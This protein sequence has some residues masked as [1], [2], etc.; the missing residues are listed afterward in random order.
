MVTGVSPPPSACGR[1]SL[2]RASLSDLDAL[3]RLRDDPAVRKYLG[4]PVPADASLEKANGVVGSDNHWVVEVSPGEVAG[5]VSL[6]PRGDDVE[7][8]YEFLP[9]YWGQGIA[10]RAC[11]DLL[12][13]QA[14]P[15]SARVVA[16]TQSSNENSRRLL[17]ALGFR[18]DHE[19]EE[20]GAVQVMYVSVG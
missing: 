17:H 3:V 4:G 8:S 12:A 2:R 13:G 18:P 1:P 11:Q 19:F 6:T 14:V 9:A 5:L 15:E 10:K 7:L 16:V 20:F